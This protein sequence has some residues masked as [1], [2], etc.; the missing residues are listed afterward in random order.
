MLNT[1]SGS[2]SPKQ[3][4]NDSEGDEWGGIDHEPSEEEEEEAPDLILNELANEG[5]SVTGKHNSLLFSADGLSFTRIGVCPPSSE[6]YKSS[7]R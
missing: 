1:I 5:K 4:D 7:S 6:K 2:G 3:D